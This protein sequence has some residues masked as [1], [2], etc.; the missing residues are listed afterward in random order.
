MKHWMAV[1]SLVVFGTQ[2]EAYGRGDVALSVG[3]SISYGMGESPISPLIRLSFD[4]PN[5][6]AAVSFEASKKLESGKGWIAGA[7][8]DRRVLGPLTVGADYHLR[9]GGGWQKNVLWAR[10]GLAYTRG[11]RLMRLTYRHELLT[12]GA[13]SNSVHALQLSVRNTKTVRIGG[14]RFAAQTGLLAINYA[15]Y[16]GKRHNGLVAQV[17]LG[18][19]RS[20]GKGARINE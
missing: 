20:V 7:E 1:C 13:D 17:W 8:V 10:V 2:A 14:V 18:V 3:S 11:G 5:T 19:A 6:Q 9:N 16:D 15:S 12:S 4:S